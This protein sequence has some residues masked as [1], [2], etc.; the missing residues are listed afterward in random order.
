VPWCDLLVLPRED[1]TTV[2]YR[3]ADKT[4]NALSLALKRTENLSPKRPAFF[5][6]E[7]CIG[8][9]VT[10][11]GH[12]CRRKG[13]TYALAIFSILSERKKRAGPAALRLGPL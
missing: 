10:F 4:S 8:L 11:D 6:I 5:K 9:S 2:I 13:L 12:V 1:L 3:I 7:S